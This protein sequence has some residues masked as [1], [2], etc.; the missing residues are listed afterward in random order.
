MITKTKNKYG[1]NPISKQ[2][3]TCNP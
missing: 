2:L 1:L 3:K